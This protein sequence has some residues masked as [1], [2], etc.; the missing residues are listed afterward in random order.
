MHTA[1]RRR[2]MNAKPMM[3]VLLLCS[4]MLHGC[5]D[6]ILPDAGNERS[7]G[8]HHIDI[9]GAGT[10]QP[11]YETLTDDRVFDQ[12][13]SE[14]H[15][16]HNDITIEGGMSGETLDDAFFR[17]TRECPELFWVTGYSATYTE[18]EATVNFSVVDGLSEEQLRRMSD[19]LD[20]AADKVAR[21]AAMYP[22]DYDRVLF[23]HDYIVEHTNYDTAGAATGVNG[24]W[25]TAYG[26]L[27]K[28]NAVCQGYAEAF[29]LL[30][31]KLGIPAGMV[32]GVTDVGLHA[33]NYVYV[34]GAYYW[35]DTT[36]DDP[37]F[38]NGEGSL[39]H[40]YFLINDEMLLRSRTIDDV[41]NGYVP[42]CTTL[43]ANY[44]VR[45]DNYLTGYQFSDID[46]RLSK[47]AAEGGIEVMFSDSGALDAAY[48][49]LFTE[50]EIWD[51]AIFK[52]RKATV[53][54]SKD[55]VMNVLRIGFV[56]Q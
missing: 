56:Y 15:Q 9:P 14:L 53:A 41:G 38:T 19:E 4:I 37:S 50:Q 13:R 7:S 28:G 29:L 55:S 47:A 33:W 17:I 25:S 52:T 31:D 27:V 24:I 20:S 21:Q 39:Q 48:E 46:L 32:A 18:A 49:A 16:F 26:C 11:I 3:A 34:N 35:L 23:V 12:M 42:V 44:F 1:F 45:N 8:E 43:D 22:S 54:Y 40:T 2:L 30:M 36:W 6:Y 5:S 51:A 10:K